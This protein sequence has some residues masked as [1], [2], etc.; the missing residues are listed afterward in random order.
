VLFHRE[1]GSDLIGGI[2]GTASV[3]LRR[4]AWLK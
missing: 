1:A 2:G 4:V 3:A